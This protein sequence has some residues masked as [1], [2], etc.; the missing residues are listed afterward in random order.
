M[1]GTPVESEA[2]RMEQ[3]ALDAI[4]EAAMLRE[5]LRIVKKITGSNV[6]EDCARVLAVYAIFE[7]D[8]T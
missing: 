3:E 7:D 2:T 4:A 5:R 8:P 6:A 1:T